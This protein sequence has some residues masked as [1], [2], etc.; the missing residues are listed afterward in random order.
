MSASA[1]G[2]KVFFFKFLGEA[3]LCDKVLSGETPYS[4]EFLSSSS[5]T[6]KVFFSD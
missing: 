2:C 1:F 3:L 5:I 6:L 4:T